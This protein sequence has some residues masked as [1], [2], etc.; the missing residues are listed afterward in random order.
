[1]GFDHKANVTSAIS[2]LITAL[3][4][5]L[6]PSLCYRITSTLRVLNSLSN[7][8]VVNKNIKLISRRLARTTPFYPL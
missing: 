3:H 1:M 2:W 8:M 6:C 4:S 7:F 5:T